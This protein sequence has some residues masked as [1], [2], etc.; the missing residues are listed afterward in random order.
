MSIIR[1]MREYKSKVNREQGPYSDINLQ[2]MQSAL[3]LLYNA[4]TRVAKSS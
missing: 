2:G 4:A 1:K 3:L